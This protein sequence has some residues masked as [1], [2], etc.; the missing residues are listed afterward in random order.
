MPYNN[1]IALPG[2]NTPKRE[3]GICESYFLIL[4][5]VAGNN[6]GWQGNMQ[7]YSIVLIAAKINIRM[8]CRLNK[9]VSSKWRKKIWIK[10]IKVTSL[11]HF[12]FKVK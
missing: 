5:Q 7:V 4:G 3:A 12:H 9:R 6:I 10:K 1:I 11:L 2:N 8:S